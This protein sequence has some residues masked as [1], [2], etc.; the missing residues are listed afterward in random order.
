MKRSLEVAHIFRAHGPAYRDVHGHTLPVRHLRVMRAIEL[1]RTAELGGHVDECDHCG[2]L[3]IFYNS[4]RNRHCPKCQCLDK[5]RW[6]EERKKDVLP[7]HYFHPV[8]T[9]P[10]DLRPLALRNQ[11]V[12]YNIL[13]RSVSETLKQL[14]R[15][16]KYLSLIHI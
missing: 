12:V 14:C 9:I 1:C 8:F 6:L 13:F 3:R 16:P 10:E 7:V 5:E 11:R 15:D 4:C 2:A